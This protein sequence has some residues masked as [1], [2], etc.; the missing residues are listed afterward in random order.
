MEEYYKRY[1]IYYAPLEN[2]ELDVFGKCWLGWD[3]YKGLETTKSDLSS[4]PN[5]QK[6]SRFVFAPK[7]YGFHG[8]IKAPFRLKDGYTY[9]DLENKVCEIS[10]Q[11]HSFHL[12]ELIIKKLGNFIALIPTNNLKVNELSN[13]FVK[14][15]D[16]L[17][18][19]LSED[20][21]KKRNPEKLTPNQKKMLYKWGYPYVFNEFKFHLTL[22]SKLNIEE[23]D[24]VFKSLQNILKQVNLS[25][26]NFNNICIF[27]QKSDEKFYFIKRFKFNNLKH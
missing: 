9:N 21:L 7:Q 3:P 2:S 16:Y 13:K 18:D 5:L 14:G 26:I 6:F 25:K 1:A 23:I 27:G 12:D 20:E 10:K 19:E 17:R 24:G 15:L 4:S 8:T 22:T 11:I